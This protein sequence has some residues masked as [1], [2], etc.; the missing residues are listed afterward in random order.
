MT[1][2][3]IFSLWPEFCI[4]FAGKINNNDHRDNIL[5]HF[6]LH[7][8]RKKDDATTF[9]RFCDENK[10]WETRFSDDEPWAPGWDFQY[11]AYKNENII[12]SYFPIR[13]KDI[14]SYLMGK[15]NAMTFSY[16]ERQGQAPLFAVSHFIRWGK[17]PALQDN[18]T[19][20]TF[21]TIYFLLDLSSS[22]YGANTWR[23]K[24]MSQDLLQY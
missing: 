7:H 16:D 19:I 22:S 2:W 20:L 12:K 13:Y 1:L 24:I 4:F 14:S 9:C 23:Y 10:W 17:H 21:Q 15:Y 18:V 5:T 6:I 8:N 3:L 11:I